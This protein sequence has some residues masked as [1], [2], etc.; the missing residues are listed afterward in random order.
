MLLFAE[1]SK[2][3]ASNIHKVFSFLSDIL[4]GLKKYARSPGIRDNIDDA[5]QPRHDERSIFTLERVRGLVE[6]GDVSSVDIS[7][8]QSTFVSWFVVARV[9]GL[10]FIASIRGGAKCIV[11]DVPIPSK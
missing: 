5:S 3:F 9:A 8:K 6:T 7:S 11:C 10:H 1:Q 4:K 2:T